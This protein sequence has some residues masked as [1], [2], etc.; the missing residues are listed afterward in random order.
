MGAQNT[1]CSKF[2]ENMRTLQATTDLFYLYRMFSVPCSSPYGIIKDS[3]QIT[4]IVIHIFPSYPVPV[5]KIHEFELVGQTQPPNDYI[6]G[7]QVPMILTMAMDT[8]QS[9]RERMKQMNPL[10]YV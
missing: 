4:Y 10:E 1:G 7:M 3:Y 2:P 8:L 6:L 9:G 5:K